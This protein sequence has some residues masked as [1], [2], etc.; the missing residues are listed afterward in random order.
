MLGK[1]GEQ[2]GLYLKTRKTKTFNSE[3]KHEMQSRLVERN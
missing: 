1:D 3:L 2:D